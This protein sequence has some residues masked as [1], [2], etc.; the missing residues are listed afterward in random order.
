MQ[1]SSVRVVAASSIR[2]GLKRSIWPPI[3]SRTNLAA[4]FAARRSTKPTKLL[5]SF[6]VSNSQFRVRVTAVL[7]RYREKRFGSF[8]NNKTTFNI[9]IFFGLYFKMEN[10][11][12]NECSKHEIN[13]PFSECNCPFKSLRSDMPKHLKESPGIHLNLMCKTL[14]MQRKQIQILTDI[15][16]KQKGQIQGIANKTESLNKFY[17]SQL[18]WKIDGYAVR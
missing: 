10:H 3:V 12:E 5:I 6:N 9:L 14:V 18:I 1:W 17:G 8:F 4:S 2:S 16:E 15:I 11:L 13:C 7:R